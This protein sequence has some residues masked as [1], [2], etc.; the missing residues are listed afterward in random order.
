[1]K[2]NEMLVYAFNTWF[3]LIFRFC[4]LYSSVK[5]D[6]SLFNLINFHPA[7]EPEAFMA[8][9]AAL[10]APLLLRA[11]HPAVGGIASPLS[12]LHMKASD[13]CKIQVLI[14]SIPAEKLE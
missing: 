10:T 9:Q 2:I 4:V 13:S 1:M 6:Y 12:A 11:R 8:L 3:Q 14:N 5:S 7:G